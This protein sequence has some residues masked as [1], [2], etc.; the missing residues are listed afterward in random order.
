MRRA[1]HP[2]CILGLA[3]G[4]LGSCTEQPGS[5]GPRPGSW[6]LTFDLDGQELPVTFQLRQDSGWTILFHNGE[7]SILVDDV[8][9]TG[10]SILVRMPL[11][12]SEFIGVLRNDSVMEGEWFNYLKGKDYRIPF[13]AE[14]GDRARFSKLAPAE[15]DLSGTWASRFSP[16]TKDAYPALGLF[17]QHGDHVTGTF[18]TETG[19]YRFL[20]GSMHGDSLW[21]SSFDGSHAFLF[22]ALLR[23]DTLHG[24][25][26]SGV[27]WQEPWMA[28]RDETFQLRDPDSLTFLREGYDMVDFNFPSIDGGTISP[29]D[30]R[31]KGKVVLIQVMGSWC[32]NCVDETKLL[33][34]VHGRYHEEGLEVIA[35]AFEKYE[36]ERRALGALRSYRDKLG[37]AYPIVYAGRSGKDQAS[38][39][40]PFLDHVMSFPT[41]IFIDRLGRVKRIRTGFYGP[42]TGEHYLRYERG[43]DA[44]LRSLLADSS[45]LTSR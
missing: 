30:E 38:A 18:G 19:D 29:K 39:K 32:P 43:L 24:R 35:V 14:A 31:Y 11:Y 3:M 8:D 27:H 36:D 10:D 12:D 34:K 44:F 9:I 20:E 21:L 2:L 26:W 13:R 40:L 15:A 45:S 17:E 33:N 22:K 1:L 23:N 42:S 6:R 5:P 25:F 16:G 37:V 4:L 28:V 41:T 7:E